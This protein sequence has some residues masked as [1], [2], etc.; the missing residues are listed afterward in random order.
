MKR[1]IFLTALLLNGCAS[2][3]VQFYTLVKPQTA[4]TSTQ[5]ALLI[6]VQPVRVPSQVDVPQLV[7]R[8]G[9]GQVALAE[10]HQWIAPLADELRDA[11]AAELS[12]QL[13]ARNVSGAARNAGV[14]AYRVQLDIQR[15]D[16]RLGDAAVIDALWTLR[17]P[18]KEAAPLL[19]STQIEEPAR[20][21]YAALVE[22]H[23]RAITRIATAIAAAIRVQQAGGGSQCPQ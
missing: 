20:G 11:L 22:A 2:A 13:G 10:S 6:D 3:P 9:S 23:Q 7:L 14:Q 5:D 21:D 8:Q 4:A 12:S 16:S 19:C 1:S 17:A 18:K 15:F